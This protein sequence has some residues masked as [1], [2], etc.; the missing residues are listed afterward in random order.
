MKKTKWV[1]FLHK[2]RIWSIW[3]EFFVESKPII[4][5]EWYYV[6]TDFWCVFL[7]CNCDKDGSNIDPIEWNK[8]GTKHYNCDRYGQCNCLVGRY[9]PTCSLG[10]FKNFN[11]ALAEYKWSEVNCKIFL[12]VCATFFQFTLLFCTWSGPDNDISFKKKCFSECA[13]DLNG[14]V[15][16]K[17]RCNNEGECTCKAGYYGP[18]CASECKCNELGTEEGSNCDPTTGQCVCINDPEYSGRDC[19]GKN[20]SYNLFTIYVLM[21]FNTSKINFMYNS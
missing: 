10:K 3:L 19:S 7:E 5:E 15:G 11:K 18:Q 6:E 17:N 20:T 13:C 9:G 16:G 21:T 12:Y 2:H 8:N 14:T 1:F 4:S